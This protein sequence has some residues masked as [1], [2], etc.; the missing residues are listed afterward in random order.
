MLKYYVVQIRT[1][2]YQEWLQLTPLQRQ[3]FEN[4]AKNNPQSRNPSVKFE[5]IRANLNMKDVLPVVDTVL[6]S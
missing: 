3:L 2:L 1:Q 6:D 4:R 5:P